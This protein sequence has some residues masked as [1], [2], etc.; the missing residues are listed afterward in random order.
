VPQPSSTSTNFPSPFNFTDSKPRKYEPAQ[1]NFIIGD[2]PTTI[3]STRLIET[4]KEFISNLTSALNGTDFN[5]S[6]R[7]A[8]GQAFATV[9]QALSTVDLKA[10]RNGPQNSSSVDAM[11]KVYEKAVNVALDALKTTPTDSLRSLLQ[12][13]GSEN[14]RKAV[15][16]A[17]NDGLKSLNEVNPVGVQAIKNALENRFHQTTQINIEDMTKSP[18]KPG[19]DKGVVQ[20]ERN[21]VVDDP[22]RDGTAGKPLTKILGG[23]IERQFV[24]GQQQQSTVASNASTVGTGGKAGNA[25]EALGKMFNNFRG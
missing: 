13:R 4:Q 1:Q 8:F 21:G 5:S 6:I 15:E 14:V 19:F 17:V 12:G 18:P 24:R 20:L 23:S 9:V 2:G 3:N 16:R 10:G 7:E 11:K 25:I 22:V